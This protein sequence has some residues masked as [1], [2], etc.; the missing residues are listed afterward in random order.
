MV[1][2]S[3]YNSELDKLNQFENEYLNQTDL[4][5]IAVAKAKRD[6]QLTKVND[7]ATLKDVSLISALALYGINFGITWKFNGL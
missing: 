4:D 1:K 3:E 5:Q 7:I 6:D 2:N